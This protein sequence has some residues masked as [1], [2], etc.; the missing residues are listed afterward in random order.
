[1]PLDSI[2]VVTV[3]LAAFT[4]FAVTLAASWWQAH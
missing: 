4:V 2:I 1:M 3:V